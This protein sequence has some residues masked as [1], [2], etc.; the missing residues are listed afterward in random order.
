M[1]MNRIEI[2]EEKK[3]ILDAF[4]NSDINK[5]NAMMA[6]IDQMAYETIYLKYLKEKSLS[7]DTEKWK[8]LEDINNQ[9]VKHS[10]TLTNIIDKMMKHLS[11]EILND[12][13]G[14]DEYN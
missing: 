9:I 10:A 12:N 6:L 3:K 8:T 7:I 4:K 5:I 1:E 11:V 14:L 13:E 2:E